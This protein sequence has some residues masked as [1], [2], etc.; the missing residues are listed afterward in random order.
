MQFNILHLSRLH[1]LPMDS[2]S[3]N[4]WNRSLSN[5]PQWHFIA[6]YSPSEDSLT[7]LSLF[8]AAIS[9]QHSKS[10]NIIFNLSS[11][12]CGKRCSMHQKHVKLDTILIY[13]SMCCIFFYHMNGSK[14]TK[15]YRN[16]CFG[17][18]HCQ[19]I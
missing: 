9:C 7:I 11:F 3:N 6:V 8:T 4:P 2:L 15:K 13:F 17:T 12:F 18:H 16:F 19:F 1:A 10:A 14:Y 5:L